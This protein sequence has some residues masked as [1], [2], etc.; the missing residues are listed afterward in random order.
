[1]PSRMSKIWLISLVFSPQGPHPILPHD[2]ANMYFSCCFFLVEN[3]LQ[4]HS[5]KARMLLANTAFLTQQRCRLPLK[6]SYRYVKVYNQ[7]VKRMGLF[8]QHTAQLRNWQQK[9]AAGRGRDKQEAVFVK[10]PSSETCK[11]QCP[12]EIWQ[13]HSHA[14]D[15]AQVTLGQ[16]CYRTV[17]TAR[18]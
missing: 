15:T 1:M 17:L 8:K 9:K 11:M 4:V 5:R 10:Q 14:I 16:S 2:H 13:Q 6:E 18:V 12:P 3:R 7:P